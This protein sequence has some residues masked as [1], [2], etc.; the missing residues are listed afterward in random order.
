MNFPQELEKSEVAYQLELLGG[1]RQRRG[2]WANGSSLDGK[3]QFQ[4]HRRSS[5]DG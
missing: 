2:R 5:P 3:G 1:H 4:V